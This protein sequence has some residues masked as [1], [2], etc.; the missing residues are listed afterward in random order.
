[1]ASRQ[2]FQIELNPAYLADTRQR[3]GNVE[4]AIRDAIA[5]VITHVMIA[6]SAQEL[7]LAFDQTVSPENVLRA[8]V[9]CELLGQASSR[10][11]VQRWLCEYLEE[12]SLSEG[13]RYQLAGVYSR[14]GAEAR[15]ASR[16]AEAVS[17]ANRGIDVV[18]DLPSSAVTANLYYNLGIALERSGELAAAIEA[19]GDS[20]EIDDLIGRYGEATLT[21]QRV[22]L[23]RT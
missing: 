6:R 11:D 22:A 16:L 17:L 14:L 19:F 3:Y 9:G 13:A 18:A 7:R 10:P 4:A 20:A 12:V 23:L 8:F 21:R 1:M 2:S 5:W 15:R